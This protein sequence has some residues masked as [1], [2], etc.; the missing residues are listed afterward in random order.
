MKD[1][2][3]YIV[4]DDKSLCDSISYLLESVHLHVKA[5]HRVE[6]FLDDYDPTRP[7]C[8]L[9]DIR[10]PDV[11]GLECQDI[12]KQRG[13]SIPIIF[14]TGHGDIS[15]AV[16][17][18]KKGAFDFVSKPFDHQSLLDRI[19]GAVKLDQE[20]RR[21]K[22]YQQ[23]LLDRFNS[24]SKREFDV[25]ENVISGKSSKVIADEMQVSPKTIEYHR[26]KISKKLNAQS[27]PD[28][29]KLFY[30]YKNAGLWGSRH[31]VESIAGSNSV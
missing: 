12:L 9:L 4:D 11:S 28:L 23:K 2:I 29:V 30:D 6:S 21:S 27:I 7:S 31:P 19:H 24:L 20:R 18:M 14:M 22:E 25:L 10:M 13:I 5:C 17:A 26:A 8:L 3:V 16:R 15:M 1:P